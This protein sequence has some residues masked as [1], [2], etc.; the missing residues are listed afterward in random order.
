MRLCIGALVIFAACA[1]PSLAQNA[2]DTDGTLRLFRREGE[3]LSIDK[4]GEALILVSCDGVEAVRRIYGK[5]GRIIRRETWSIPQKA[6]TKEDVYS[7]NAG[8]M[9][10]CVTNEGDKAKGEYIVLDKRFDDAGNII[11]EKKWSVLC[12]GTKEERHL[13]KAVSRTYNGK[14]ITQEVTVTRGEGGK[15]QVVREVHQGD[16]V[17]RYEDGILRMS[18][19]HTSPDDYTKM[20]VAGEGESAARIVT[21]YVGGRKVSTKITR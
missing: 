6:M 13:L 14:E 15:K 10:R 8:K 2:L 9:V 20:V 11:E 1:L 17:Y 18:E 16:D 7:Y 12:G 5:N 4:R 3:T 21:V 19:V